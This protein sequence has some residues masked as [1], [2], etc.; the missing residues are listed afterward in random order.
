MKPED[1]TTFRAVNY[2]PRLNAVPSECSGYTYSHVASPERQLLKA[3]GRGLLGSG[4]DGRVS[5]D[6]TH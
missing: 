5:P 3:V 4:R 6:S 2:I 1:Q